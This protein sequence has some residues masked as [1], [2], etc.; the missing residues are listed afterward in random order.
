MRCS[1]KDIPLP[2][3]SIQSTAK[4][5]FIELPPNHLPQDQINSFYHFFFTGISIVH[6]G[7]VSLFAKSNRT[8]LLNYE[9]IYGYLRLEDTDKV[10]DEKSTPRKIG[11]A[12]RKIIIVYYT[13]PFSTKILVL[14][15][16]TRVSQ[17]WSTWIFHILLS[18]NKH[19]ILT[20]RS[21]IWLY[22][23][24]LPVGLSK[25]I[26]S[27]ISNFRKIL[28]DNFKCQALSSFPC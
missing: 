10:K 15:S 1:I 12:F 8:I 27:F 23:L 18:H 2:P 9:C 3:D 21:F 6:H 24:S 4:P 11:N 14:K 28:K 22:P 19:F 16:H 17:F 7:L 25:S 13:S 5:H 20:S 26:F